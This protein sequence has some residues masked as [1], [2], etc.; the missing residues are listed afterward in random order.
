M[1]VETLRKRFEIWKYILFVNLGA[2]LTLL[3]TSIADIPN[4]AYIDFP[5]WYGVWFVAQL[6]SF[7]P[8]FVLLW[9]RHWMQIPLYERLNTIFGYFVAAWITMLSF[10]VRMWPN[11][12]TSFTYFFLGCG[13]VIAIG[14]VWLR[15]KA[16]GIQNEI[17]P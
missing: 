9:G 13:A 14:Y 6:A 4:L 10:G 1:Q 5:G 3:A 7:L 12:P 16:L 15:Q 11:I 17:F 2:S 8:G